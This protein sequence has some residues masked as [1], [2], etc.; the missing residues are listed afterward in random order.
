VA[1]GDEDEKADGRGGVA[2]AD[3]T[4]GGEAARRQTETMRI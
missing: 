4:G 1:G 2:V 3:E